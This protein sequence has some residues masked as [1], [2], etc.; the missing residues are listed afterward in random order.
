MRTV[1]SVT[2]RAE[3]RVPSFSQSRPRETDLISPS[4][5]FGE[6]KADNP[7][8]LDCVATMIA[9]GPGALA[10]EAADAASD[11]LAALGAEKARPDWLAPD[12]ACDLFFSGLDTDQADAALRH[13]LATRFPEA[14]IDI[15]VQKATGRRK[16][17]AVADME[18]TL[19]ENEML[20]ELADF[21]GARDAVAA[22]TRRT[23]NGEIDFVKSLTSRTAL[24]TGLPVTVLDEAA[25]RI[26]PA[27]G[28]ATLVATMRARGAFVALVSGGF[29][30]FARRVQTML[31]CDAAICNE[32][33]IEGGKLTG[34]LREPVLSQYGKLAAMKTLAAERGIPLDGTLAVGDGANDLPMIEAA[35]LGVAFRAKPAV[36]A[37][38]RLR[39]DHAN[40]TALLYAQ[41]YRSGEFM[42]G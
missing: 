14:P 31:G 10:A 19:I 33:D 41:G 18:A 2:P 16:R 11:A 7:F 28:A 38:A 23:M 30:V 4:L 5:A 20:D 25:A 17:L 15:V 3:A 40:L 29:G 42:T 12:T 36:A 21:I 9:A 6:P 32:L 39:I 22:I 24:F 26:R 27:P 1:F 34:K 8:M 13:L 37:R 35:G